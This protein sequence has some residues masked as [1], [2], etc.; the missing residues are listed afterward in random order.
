MHVPQLTPT[1]ARA[2]L[3]ADEDH[4]YLDVRTVPEFVAGHAPGALNIPVAEVNPALGRMEGNPHFLR[5]VEALVP[6]DKPIVVGCKSGGRSQMA[7]E[8]LLQAGFRTVFNLKG[9]FHGVCGPG[10]EIIE[11][12]WCTLGLPMERGDGG[13]QGYAALQSRVGV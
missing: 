12:G 5:H 8:M 7:A 1:E 13:P 9:G 3:E 2:R 10:G 6:K 11:E 4:V